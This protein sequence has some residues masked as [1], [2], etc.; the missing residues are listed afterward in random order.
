MQAVGLCDDNTIKILWCTTFESQQNVLCGSTS[1]K[2]KL[3]PNSFCYVL[4]PT[5]FNSC[6]AEYLHTLRVN[7]DKA[8]V[9]L[10]VL[11]QPLYLS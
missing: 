5:D 7:N 11:V 10:W 4:T 2:T 3:I 6:I 1:M 9:G 8:Q